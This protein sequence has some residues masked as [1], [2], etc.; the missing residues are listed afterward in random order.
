[1]MIASAAGLIVAIVGQNGHGL[2]RQRVVSFGPY[3]ALAIWI[4]WLVVR[5]S[6]RVMNSAVRSR[7]RLNLKIS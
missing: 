3:L 2:D 4:T 1:M 7:L 5:L 6:W